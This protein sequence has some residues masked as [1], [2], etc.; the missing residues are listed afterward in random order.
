M[1]SAATQLSPSW[2]L[3]NR[4][5][6]SLTLCNKT[7]TGFYGASD[8]SACLLD[9]GR[10]V[11][12]RLATAS[13]TLIA[14]VWAPPGNS[15]LLPLRHHSAFMVAAAAGVNDG[16]S[17]TVTTDRPCAADACGSRLMSATPRGCQF[18]THRLMP[19]TSP[20]AR[21]SCIHYAKCLA[22]LHNYY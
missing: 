19:P 6:P 5:V 9:S 14:L 10:L 21:R 12:N 8:T 2:T 11:N 3:R 13:R 15:Q 16:M 20:T 22:M 1:T 18:W 4:P 7:L 17:S